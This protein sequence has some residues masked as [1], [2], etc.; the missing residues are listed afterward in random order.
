LLSLPVGRAA[1]GNTRAPA[2]GILIALMATD[3]PT[4]SELPVLIVVP[5]S[6]GCDQPREQLDSLLGITGQQ[7][8]K[9]RA[10]EHRLGTSVGLATAMAGRRYGRVRATRSLRGP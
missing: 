5:A 6:R 4:V 2:T 7:R 9:P 3:T 8:L 1:I 10:A